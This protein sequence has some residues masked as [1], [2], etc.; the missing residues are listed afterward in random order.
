MNSIP[1]HIQSYAN[2]LV[3][4]MGYWRAN[5]VVIDSSLDSPKI[6]ERI[7][8]GYRKNSTD[9]YVPRSYVNKCQGKGIYYQHAF[10]KLA[11]PPYDKL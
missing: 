10:T 1:K 2:S 8:S 6:L 3:R 7:D 4:K 11:I 5:E 9:E